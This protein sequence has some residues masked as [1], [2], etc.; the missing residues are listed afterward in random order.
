MFRV[1]EEALFSGKATF[2]DLVPSAECVE[3]EHVA[4]N[5]SIDYKKLLHQHRKIYAQESAT[6]AAVESR[7]IHVTHGLTGTALAFKAGSVVANIGNSTISVD[8]KKNGSSILSAPI[9]LTSSNTA[10]QLVSGTISSPGLVVGDVLEVSI[11]VSAGS[12]TLGKG[13]FCYLDL[14]EKPE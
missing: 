3:N 4:E 2:K 7:V 8:L 10:R 14:S 5:A 9:S 13:V 12:G 6:T 1:E 11:A